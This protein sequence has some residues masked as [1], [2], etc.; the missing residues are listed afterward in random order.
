MFFLF[1]FYVYS[2][3][4]QSLKT[5][6][7]WIRVFTQTELTLWNIKAQKVLIQDHGHP[8]SWINPSQA[9]GA[10]RMSSQLRSPE[11][12]RIVKAMSNDETRSEFMWETQCHQP[13]MTGYAS[14]PT[15]WFPGWFLPL[16]LPHQC[17]SSTSK[18]FNAEHDAHHSILISLLKGIIIHHQPATKTYSRVR[19]EQASVVNSFTQEYDTIQLTLW[20][21]NSSLLKMT[22][23]KYVE[24]VSFPII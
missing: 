16:G 15:W 2:V 19:G 21:F 4:N 11:T 17:R 13:T 8:F 24:I 18:Q 12:W 22:Q 5:K 23:S 9:L 3:E 6:S 1:L 7:K 10:A 14:N 20:S